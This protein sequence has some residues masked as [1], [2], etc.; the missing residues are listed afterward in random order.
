M[1]L[2]LSRTTLPHPR[3]RILRMLAA[4][5]LEGEGRYPA[6]PVSTGRFSSCV[7][8]DIEPS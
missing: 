6:G 4:P 8:S 7:H 3:L 2:P 5:P 1:R